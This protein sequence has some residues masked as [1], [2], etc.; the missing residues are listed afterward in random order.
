MLICLTFI[1]IDEGGLKGLFGEAN[2]YI[3]QYLC[4]LWNDGSEGKSL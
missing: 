4:A 1:D 3:F 2:F